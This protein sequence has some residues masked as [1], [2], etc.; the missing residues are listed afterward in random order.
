MDTLSEKFITGEI[1]GAFELSDDLEI[2]CL[3]WVDDALTLTIG[4]ENTNNVLNKVDEFAKVNKLQWGLEKCQVMQIG[5]KVKVPEKWD[6]GSEQIQNTSSYRYLN[7]EL[8]DNCKN[9][10]NI[11]SRENKVNA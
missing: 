1:P 2:G 3:E 11:I 9:D 4:I 8:T 5:K 7:D 10:K 6:L